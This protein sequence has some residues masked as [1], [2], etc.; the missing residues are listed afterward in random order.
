MVYLKDCDIVVV[1]ETR[2]T[3][4]VLDAEI[5]PYGYDIYRRD[6]YGDKRGGGVLIAVKNGLESRRRR[7]SETNCELVVCEINPLTDFTGLRNTL[8]HT[9]F[10]ISL[11][12]KDIDQSWENWR[13]LFLTTVDMYMPKFKIS[14]AKSPKW[15]DGE[16][17]GLSKRK[18]KLW[19]SKSSYSY[20][21]N[22]AGVNISLLVIIIFISLLMSVTLAEKQGFNKDLSEKRFRPLSFLNCLKWTSFKDKYLCTANYPPGCKYGFYPWNGFVQFMLMILLCGDISPNPGPCSPSGMSDLS[23][24]LVNARSLKSIHR[25]EQDVITSELNMNCFQNY[26]YANN[27][28]VVAVTETWL[29][30]DVENHEILPYGYQVFRRDRGKRGGGVLFA[31]RSCFGD[32]QVMDKLNDKFNI[33]VFAIRL[34]NAS[35]VNVLLSVVYRPPTSDSCGSKILGNI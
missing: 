19:R 20:T 18:D 13:D 21:F 10:D 5:L 12:G 6:R 27:F 1:C 3:S 8:L 17:V 29:S 35:G 7:H 34:T 31:I 24:F 33:E 30:G 4:A 14:D 22:M 26:I 15:I 9:P 11:N 2:L 28:D 32:V 16:V 23:C 25:V